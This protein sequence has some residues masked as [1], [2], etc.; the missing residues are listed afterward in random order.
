MF[1]AIKDIA[2]EM[3]SFG[4]RKSTESE[5]KDGKANRIFGL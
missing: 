3:L 4:C 5:K 2:Q 1:R